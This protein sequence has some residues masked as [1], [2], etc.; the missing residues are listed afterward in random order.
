MSSWVHHNPNQ[1][2]GPTLLI[3]CCWDSVCLVFF[4][5]NVFLIFAVMV[6][7]KFC[8][9]NWCYKLIIV[10]ISI[11]CYNFLLFVHEILGQFWGVQLFLH[12]YWALELQSPID[13]G[14]IFNV[15]KCH[16]PTLAVVFQPLIARCGT[17]KRFLFT[18]TNIRGLRLIH[19]SLLSLCFAT[20]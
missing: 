14:F 3:R 13:F 4:L 8:E 16:A 2:V 12:I 17:T 10:V 9:S 5:M 20:K 15:G 18:N 6:W 19:L 7:C 1:G 11:C